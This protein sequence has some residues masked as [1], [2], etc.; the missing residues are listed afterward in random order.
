MLA[1][2]MSLGEDLEQFFP[3][4]NRLALVT[5]HL[6]MLYIAT[7]HSSASIEIICT[8]TGE[9]YIRSHSLEL[10]HLFDPKPDLFSK[11]GN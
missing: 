6:P 11:A 3:N 10:E 7:N 9:T 4:R 8:G 2:L 5:D 1:L